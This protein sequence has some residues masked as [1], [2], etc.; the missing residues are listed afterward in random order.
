MKKTICESRH[1]TAVLYAGDTDKL[2]DDLRITNKLIGHA[3][4]VDVKGRVRWHGC[5]NAEEE[6]V[7]SL[8]RCTRDLEE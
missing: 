8:L 7:V 6:E 1:D 4:L 2:C 5:G 3:F